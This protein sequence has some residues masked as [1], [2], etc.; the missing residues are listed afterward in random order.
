MDL[1]IFLA[2]L[3]TGYLF[4]SWAERRH[5]MA[6]ETREKDFLHLPTTNSKEG[7]VSSR[8]V[9]CQ[10][11]QGNAV[12]SVDYC[13]RLLA[14][15]RNLFGGTIRS[16]ETLVDRAR[17]EAIL[18]MKEAAPAGTTMIVNVRIETATIGKN[19]HKKGV[20]CVEAI[21]YGTALTV[22][23]SDAVHSPPA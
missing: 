4:G 3:A 11:V 5:Y 12:I 8:V 6:I 17:R 10:M 14:S 13:K 1:I 23:G 9:H 16:Y 7:F 20:G 21:A 15:L 22:K 18:R 2:L 19:A